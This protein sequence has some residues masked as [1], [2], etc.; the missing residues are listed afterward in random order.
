[1]L[2]CRGDYGRIEGVAC[3]L[4]RGSCSVRKNFV[5]PWSV[6]MDMEKLSCIRIIHYNGYTRYLC[7]QASYI[8]HDDYVHFHAIKYS[9]LILLRPSLNQMNICF[10]KIR[11]YVYREII[12]LY[13]CWWSLI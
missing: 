4:T 6:D 5:A 13:V 1:M 8:C 3:T 11:V 9:T 10:W 2:S 7:L 12:G